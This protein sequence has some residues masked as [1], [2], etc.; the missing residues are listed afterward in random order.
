MT[1]AENSIETAESTTEVPLVDIVRRSMEVATKSS[2]EKTAALRRPLWIRRPK[3]PKGHV[4][5]RGTS[6]FVRGGSLSPATN[7]VA[8]QTRTGLHMA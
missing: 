5:D 8:K 4:P 1:P 7:L 2:A 6:G 3:Q